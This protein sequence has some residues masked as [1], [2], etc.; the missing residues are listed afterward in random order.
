[1]YE[2]SKQYHNDTITTYLTL[3]TYLSNQIVRKLS[4]FL[5]YQALLSSIKTASTCPLK[6]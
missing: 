2:T 1:M 5:M 4:V 3:I 6:L